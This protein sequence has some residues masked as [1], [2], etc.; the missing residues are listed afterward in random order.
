MQQE[1]RD[2][3]TSTHED[4]A[5]QHAWAYSSRGLLV[6]SQDGNP[7]C[8]AIFSRGASAAGGGD[9]L[10][11]ALRELAGKAG[12]GGCSYGVEPVVTGPWT[13]YVREANEEGAGPQIEMISAQSPNVQEIGCSLSTI[14][15]HKGNFDDGSSLW[16]PK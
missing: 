16:S 6:I 14:P 8:P 1:E 10:D 13:D 11:A 5:K 9:E 4:V 7:Q 15:L 12:Q 3:P 2:E